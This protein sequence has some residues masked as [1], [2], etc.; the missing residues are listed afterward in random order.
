VPALSVYSLRLAFAWGIS[1]ALLGGWTLFGKA[2]FAI[3]PALRELH[4][5]FMLHGWMIQVVFATAFW[6]FPRI[7]QVRPRPA[8]AVAGILLWNA[9]LLMSAAGAWMEQAALAA[10]ILRFGGGACMA[11]HFLPRLRSANV[12]R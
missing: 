12:Q 2:V 1:G 8:F 10:S 3:N 9:S 4:T 5:H 6:I 11:W 7:A